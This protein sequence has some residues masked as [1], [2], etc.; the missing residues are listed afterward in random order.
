MHR[1]VSHGEPN[2]WH[3][4]GTVTQMATRNRRKL[5]NDAVRDAPVLAKR[6]RLW[7]TK[8]PNLFVSIAPSGSKPT[9][10]IVLASRTG[11]LRYVKR[12]AGIDR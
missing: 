6:Y 3:I 2:C 10:L 1:D 4:A 9:A 11:A 7:D 12:N 5:T 8:I